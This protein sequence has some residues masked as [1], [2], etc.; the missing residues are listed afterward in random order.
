VGF[1]DA[2]RSVDACGVVCGAI[3]GAVRG[4][5]GVVC[6]VFGLRLRLRLRLAFSEPPGRWTRWRSC[7]W[8]LWYRGKVSLFC[9]VVDVVEVSLS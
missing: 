1:G 9:A 2:R 4:V 5:G 8:W 7:G 6:A 3:G